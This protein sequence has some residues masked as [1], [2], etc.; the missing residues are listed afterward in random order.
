MGQLKIYV[1]ILLIV[2][3]LWYKEASDIFLYFTSW[4][5][6]VVI[7]EKKFNASGQRQYLLNDW[8]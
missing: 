1:L 3:E 6:Q 2:R 5:F 7:M 4:K 8:W